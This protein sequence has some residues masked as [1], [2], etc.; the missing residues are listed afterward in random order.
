MLPAVADRPLVMKRFPNGVGGKPFYQHRA[1]DVRPACAS[2]PVSVSEKPAANRSA[3][4]SRRSST[5][6]SWRRSRR[7]PGSPASSR[8][9]SPTTW[10]SISI[11]PL[12][13]RSRRARRRPL[14]PGRAGLARRD[15]GVPRPP[16]RTVCTSTFR[17]LPTPVRCRSAVLSDIATVVRASTP[18]SPP[19]NGRSA[20]G[21]GACTSTVCRTSSEDTRDRLQR[22][23]ERLRGGVDTAHV[24]RGRRRRS[25]RRFTLETTPRAPFRCGRSMGALAGLERRGSVRR[26]EVSVDQRPDRY[27]CCA[28]PTYSAGASTRTPPPDGEWS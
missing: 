18:R 9:S 20:R 16:G 12:V 1:A 15:I 2:E 17:S 7:I 8:R 11:R 24:G 26:L 21:A 3:A 13:F 28:P 27:E 5:R 10:R 4:R 23:C 25:P 22:T 14:D 6:P 19:S